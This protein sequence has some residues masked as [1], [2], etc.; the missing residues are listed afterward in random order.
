ML[1]IKAGAPGHVTI[2]AG[3]LMFLSL[4]EG[5]QVAQKT[6]PKGAV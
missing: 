4:P 2:C 5:S 6:T 3:Y 1:D